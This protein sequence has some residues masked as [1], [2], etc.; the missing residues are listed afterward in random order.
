MQLSGPQELKPFFLKHQGED[1]LLASN[2]MCIYVFWLLLVY[3]KQKVWKRLVGSSSEISLRLLM[4]PVQARFAIL[5][6]STHAY[7]STVADI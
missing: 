3:W 1:T 6:I 4:L 7:L 5:V 2:Y